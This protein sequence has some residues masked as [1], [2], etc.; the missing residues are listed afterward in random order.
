V[1]MNRRITDCARLMVSFSGVLAGVPYLAEFS[2]EWHIY[3]VEPS[4]N[5]HIAE[6]YGIACVQKLWS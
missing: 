2:S 1:V 5:S 4:W 3:I 6:V